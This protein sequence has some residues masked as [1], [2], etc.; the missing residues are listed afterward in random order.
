MIIHENVQQEK[1]NGGEKMTNITIIS[2]E[3][4]ATINFAINKIEEIRSNINCENQNNRR[5]NELIDSILDIEE[6]LTMVVNKLEDVIT[7]KE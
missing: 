2:T 3:E 1:L 7:V 4:I 5:K 6:A